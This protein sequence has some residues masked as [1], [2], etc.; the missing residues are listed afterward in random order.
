MDR[1]EVKSKLSN[2]YKG[3][4]IQPSLDDQGQKVPRTTLGTETSYVP[5]GKEINR[6]STSSGERTWTSYLCQV[7]S[8]PDPPLRGSSATPGP[9]SRPPGLGAR[10][11]VPE[12][13]LWSWAD[14][15]RPDAAHGT[16]VDPPRP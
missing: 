13:P 1:N 6:D 15:T 11:G 2:P 3:M 4:E 10:R 5:G 16:F 7:T 12:D 8:A 14:K 9:E